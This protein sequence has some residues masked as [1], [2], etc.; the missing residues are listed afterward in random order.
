MPVAKDAAQQLYRS[1]YA[2]LTGDAALTLLL[3][4]TGPDNPK[5]Y[6]S[7][8]DFDSTFAL[9]NGQWVTF[10]IVADRPFEIEQMQDVHEV[11]L[12]VHSW[13]RGPGSTIAETVDKRTRELLDD[14]ALSTDNLFS[15]YCHYS[16]YS[17]N[18]EPVPQLWHVTSTYHILCM[19]QE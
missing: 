10:N 11:V 19:A 4:V 14:A 6:Q 7:F 9:K 18:Y 13:V 17:K 3:A 8:I 2:I 12:D 15:W 16:G 1:V 5:V